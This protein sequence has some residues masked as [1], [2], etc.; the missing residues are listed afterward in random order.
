MSDLIREGAMKLGLAA[1]DEKIAKIERFISEIELFNP[2]YRLVSYRERDELIIRHVLDS[3]A[4]VPELITLAN[5][6]PIADLGSGAGFPGI[7]IAIFC[8]GPVVLVERMKR[9][10]DFLR[11]VILRCNLKNVRVV[12]K[13]VSEVDEKFPVITCRAFHPVYDIIS[14]VDRILETDG[15]FCAYKGRQSY[16]QAETE[17]LGKYTCTSVPLKVPFL[18]EERCLALIRREEV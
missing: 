5:G 10:V 11:N 1:D 14:D 15:V 12:C 16:L 3:M 8:D 18:D 17:N 6:R 2:V 4:G 9:R 13:D 7:I